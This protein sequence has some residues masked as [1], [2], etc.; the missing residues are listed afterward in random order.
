[1]NEM[2]KEVEEWSRVHK[3]HTA[4]PRSQ[5]LKV[6]NEFKKTLKAYDD[7][8]EE[9][10]TDG[11][12]VTYVSLVILCQQL[13]IDFKEIQEKSGS[14]PTTCHTRGINRLSEGVSEGNLHLVKRAVLGLLNTSN[15]MASMVGK[16]PNECLTKAFNE[17]K[18]T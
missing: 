12:G 9:E 6:T 7:N 4:D 5:A 2:I 13:N 18:I 15:F 16:E 1:M 10:I 11:I 17:I 14:V 3:L 8:I